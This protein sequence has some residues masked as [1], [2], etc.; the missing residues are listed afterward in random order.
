MFI[1]GQLLR[2]DPFIFNNGNV[3]GEQVDEYTQSY[4][5]SMGSNVEDLGIMNLESLNAL[6]ICLKQSPLIKIKYSKLL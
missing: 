5:D 1:E 3:Y 4:L 6:R 2:F